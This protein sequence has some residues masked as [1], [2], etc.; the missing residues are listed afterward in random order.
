VVTEGTVLAQLQQDEALDQLRQARDGV[1]QAERALE[2]ARKEQGT[3]IR[4]A[5]TALRDAQEDLQAL[6]PGGANDPIRAAQK[7]LE[8]AQRAARDANREGSEGKTQAEFDLVAKTEAL[9][10]SQDAYSEAFWDN[11]WAQKYGTDPNT[12]VED[13]V[14][15]EKTRPK[16]TEQ[17]IKEFA[18]ALLKAERAVRDAERAVEQAVRALDLA[19]QQEVEG[20]TDADKTVQEKQ[21]ALDLLLNG[22]GNKELIQA[23]RQVS[24]RELALE[25]ARQGDFTS[26]IKAI[27]DARR[28]LERAEKKVTDGQIIAPQNGEV[29]SISLREGDSAEAFTP[30]IE[31]ADPA[32]LEI[33][34]EIGADQLRQLA[35]G[36]P[37]TISLLA[38][39]DVLMPAVIRRMPG[40]RGGSGAVQDQDR[41]T[42]FTINDLKGQTLQPGA[43]AKISIV[44]ERKE[45]VLL[46]PKDAVRAFEGRRFVV[47]R[48]GERERRVSV[49]IGIETEDQVEVLDGV[50]EGDVVVGN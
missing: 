1:A 16:L 25:E 4:Q 17:Q 5:E 38:R 50:K 20:N 19:R 2:Q 43:V 33:G 48:E 32:N 37:A 14:T 49:Q 24:E 44:L 12:E 40:G 45:N 10:D 8:E 41:T 26:E 36:Q 18:D 42:R 7:E 22:S 27:E 21:A 11:D 9:Q 46:L 47:V 30:V 23:Q 28:S 3:R 13:P 35:E 31:I 29:L 15:G 34:A 6:L 39:P